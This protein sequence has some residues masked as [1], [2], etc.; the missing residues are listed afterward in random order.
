[1]KRGILSAFIFILMILPFYSCFDDSDE[2]ELSPQEAASL[3][4]AVYSEVSSAASAAYDDAA[5]A[6]EKTGSAGNIN[7]ANPDE[8]IL[9]T[10]NFSLKDAAII[11]DYYMTV[12]FFDYT[13]ADEIVIDGSTSFDL[14]M[15][16]PVN[17]WYSYTGSF[18][19]IYYGVP[20]SL[21]WNMKLTILNDTYSYSGYYE[22]D[23]TRYEYS[24]IT[25][26]VAMR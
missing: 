1:M 14:D 13:G 11:Y 8:S 16:S 9:V 2:N 23:G 17:L 19:V 15:A 10:G 20:Y 26:G 25:G 5:S 12:N 22:I 24:D 3:Y 7:Y 6:L 4:S 21:S 18:S